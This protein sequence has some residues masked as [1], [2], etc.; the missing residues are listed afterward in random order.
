MT[1]AS[2][3]DLIDTGTRSMTRSFGGLLVA[4]QRRRDFRKLLKLDNHLLTDM[5]VTRAEVQAAARL[6]VW[7]DAAEE[8]RR[9]SDRRRGQRR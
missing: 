3:S 4:I 9:V 1:Y 6:P 7:I 2:H 8:L 5:G